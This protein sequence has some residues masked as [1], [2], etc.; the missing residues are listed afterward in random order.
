MSIIHVDRFA[1]TPNN[2]SFRGCGHLRRQPLTHKLRSVLTLIGVVIGI[3]PR[4]TDRNRNALGYF[5]EIREQHHGRLAIVLAFKNS[6]LAA[7]IRLPN[8]QDSHRSPV[9]HHEKLLRRN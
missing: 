7:R 6:H 9:G 8:L 2:E 4:L 5:L 3:A 1:V